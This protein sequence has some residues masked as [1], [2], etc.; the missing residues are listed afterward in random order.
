MA[1]FKKTKTKEVVA[2]KAL[3]TTGSLVAPRAL[4]DISSII[5]RPRITEK[6]AGGYEQGVYVFDV[7]VDANISL[8]KSAIIALYKVTPRKINIVTVPIK[9]VIVRGRRGTKGGG[10]KAYVFLKKGDK[11]EI[12]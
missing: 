6:S 8:I 7:R 12:A 11:I 4:S 3:R 1:L 9:N 5:V 10:K 2:E